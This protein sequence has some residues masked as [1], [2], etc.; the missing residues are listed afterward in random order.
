MI[1]V[2]QI[3]V[4]ARGGARRRG[5]AAAGNPKFRRRWAGAGAARAFRVFF[6]LG[7]GLP[8]FPFPSPAS[9]ATRRD[10]ARAPP[11]RRRE[12]RVRDSGWSDT[13]RVVS[14]P[15][16]HGQVCCLASQSALLCSA[17][18]CGKTRH[19]RHKKPSSRVTSSRRQSRLGW[20]L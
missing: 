19:A 13:C 9:A 16:V 18:P 17:L 5:A 1:C 14:Q 11:V 4:D 20:L 12:D 2:C 6:L 8:P 7:L 15:S 3:K 10:E